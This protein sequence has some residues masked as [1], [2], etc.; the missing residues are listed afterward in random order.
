MLRR[1]LYKAKVKNHKKLL[2]GRVRTKEFVEPS[3]VKRCLL[4]RSTRGD[5]SCY[6]AT[7]KEIF[8]HIDFVE[9]WHVS[10]GTLSPSDSNAITIS[11]HNLTKSGY[12]DADPAVELLNTPFDWYIDLSND[13]S[14]LAELLLLES[15]AKCKISWRYLG[16]FVADITVKDL[17][18]RKEFVSGLKELFVT[19][20]TNVDG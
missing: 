11:K 20:S 14:E 15:M 16:N 4:L 18:G 7:L 9:L 17:K 1:L 12:K 6:V 3:Q 10:T 5:N 8:P 13:N 2:L 19:L